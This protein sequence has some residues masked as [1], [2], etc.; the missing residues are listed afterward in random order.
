MA[1]AAGRV[2]DRLQKPYLNRVSGPAEGSGELHPFLRTH[3]KC[4]EV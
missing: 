2:P 1:L 4:G 3:V